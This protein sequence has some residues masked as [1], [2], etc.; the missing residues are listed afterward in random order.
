MSV[1]NLA[2]FRR[3]MEAAKTLPAQAL[4]TTVR[5]QFVDKWRMF[6]GLAPVRSGAHRASTPYRG[7][8]PGAWTRTEGATYPHPGDGPARAIAEAYRAGERIGF[9]DRAQTK[10]GF[11]PGIMIQSP[12]SR[13]LFG[14][15]AG[16]RPAVSPQ[17]P[18]GDYALVW[19]ALQQ[20]FMAQFEDELER[21][22]REAA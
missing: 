13:P 11:L 16:S 14:F 12:A 15:P 19:R 21:L 20:D 8:L 1:V 22:F 18:A 7:E 10:R 4:E 9:G 5:E 6:L 2:E 3:E 17:A